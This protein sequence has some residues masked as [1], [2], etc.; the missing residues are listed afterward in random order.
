ML[1]IKHPIWCRISYNLRLLISQFYEKSRAARAARTLIT[2]LSDFDIELTMI[3][4]HI[5]N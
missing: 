2:D 1:Y 3:E 5:K 4:N